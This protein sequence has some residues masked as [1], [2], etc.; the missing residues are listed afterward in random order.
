MNERFRRMLDRARIG[1]TRI[2][3]TA[4][5]HRYWLQLGILTLLALAAL[6]SWGLSSIRR[7]EA[8]QARLMDLERVDAAYDRWIRDLQLPTPA[9]SL[10]WR[11]SETA[12]ADLGEEASRSLTIARLIAARAGEVGVSNL[13]VSQAPVESMPSVEEVVLGGWEAQPA[14]EGLVVEF[15]A[16]FA[17]VMAFL[18]ALPIQAAVSELNLSDA[19]GVL[20]ARVVIAT[21]R[22]QRNG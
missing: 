7:E 20:H 19:G 12:L 2:A 18:A 6:G 8:G 13:R 10:A 21:R 16:T 3:A 11:E 15:D 1:G 4:S 17:G 14:G 5:E 9:E 22:I